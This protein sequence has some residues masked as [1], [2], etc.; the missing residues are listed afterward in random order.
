MVFAP[1]SFHAY[2][3]GCYLSGFRHLDTPLGS[4]PVDTRANA[5]L[6]AQV[7]F[8]GEEEEEEELQDETQ[9]DGLEVQL[10]FIRKVFEGRSVRVL[11]LYVPIK[12]TKDSLKRMTK[13]LA[14]LVADPETMIVVSTNLLDWD[15]DF[16]SMYVDEAKQILS[17]SNFG[18][19]LFHQFNMDPSFETIAQYRRALQDACM[20]AISYGDPDD[21]VHNVNAT[22]AHTAFS[23]TLRRN[24]ARMRG[25]GGVQLLLTMMTYMHVVGSETV[26]RFIGYK[27]VRSAPPGSQHITS[28]A[29]AYI[30]IKDT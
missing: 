12:H 24:G 14:P 10:P 16:G 27:E 11:P 20:R 13:T 28:Y 6:G 1:S 29:S 18:T 23:R 2:H 3:S 25:G 26:C 21:L 17:E 30:M 5:H 19:S 9:E 8:M 7:L 15:L 22:A 4:L